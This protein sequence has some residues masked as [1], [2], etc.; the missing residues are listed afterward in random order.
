MTGG[1]A[2]RAPLGVFIRATRHPRIPSC[3]S[4][5]IFLNLM[6]T[7]KLSDRISAKGKRTWTLFHPPK[8]KKR[9]ESDRLNYFRDSF[10]R[11]T[12]VLPPA[13]LLCPMIQPI[14]T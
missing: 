5:F 14:S 4:D 12:F 1:N 7:L 2:K 3:V 8:G 10:G 6:T 13:V 11:A 9:F